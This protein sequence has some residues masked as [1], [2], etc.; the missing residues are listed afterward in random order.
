MLIAVITAN[1]SIRVD[2]ENPCAEAQNSASST[3]SFKIN[4]PK[5]YLICFLSLNF[6]LT[7]EPSV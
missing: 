6:P 5:P 3:L 2:E 4:Q 1:N 7:K